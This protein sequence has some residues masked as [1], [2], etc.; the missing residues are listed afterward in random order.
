MGNQEVEAFLNH[1]AVK[2]NCSPN[3]QKLALNALVF[4]F[5]EFLQIEL[6]LKFNYSKR[7]P[8]VPVVF[9]HAEAM[10]VID[11]MQGVNQHVT[12]LMYG[13]GLQIGEAVSLRVKDIDFGMNTI[14]VRNGKGRKD[15]VTILPSGL[16]K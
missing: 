9:T 3:T 13:S 1:L 2:N 6:T 8:R 11:E 4:L 10:A 14:A 15:R 16:H 5:R 7:K 12:S